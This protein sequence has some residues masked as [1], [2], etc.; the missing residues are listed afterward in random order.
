MVIVCVPFVNAAQKTD[1]AIVLGGDEPS[2]KRTAVELVPA[3]P[4]R[5]P[6]FVCESVESAYES[7]APA[8]RKASGKRARGEDGSSVGVEWG[9]G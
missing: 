6:I 5:P 1:S 9:G 7:E 8:R 3:L 2:V 4:H